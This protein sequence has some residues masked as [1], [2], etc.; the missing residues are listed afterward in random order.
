G[1]VVELQV[2]AADI[3]ERAH[4]LAIG[5]AEILEVRLEVGIDLLADRRS[6][7]AEVQH[8]RRRNGHL[9]RNA[10][11]VLDELEIGDVRM[12]R[13]I[14]LADNPHAFGL[15]VDAVKLDAAGNLK[16]LDTV[17]LGEEIELP[18]GAA[19]FAVGGE[20]QSDLFL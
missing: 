11:V 4:R 12:R 5:V 16:K 18:P 6:S 2:A 8:A 20:V 10:R 13:I 17:E 1:G 9:G 19:A 7:L 14:D 3:V 15:G